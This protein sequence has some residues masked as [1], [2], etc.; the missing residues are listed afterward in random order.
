MQAYTES[1]ILSELLHDSAPSSRSVWTPSD[2]TD[3]DCEGRVTFEF[4]SRLL[5]RVSRDRRDLFQKL[6]ISRRNPRV[7]KIAAKPRN[8]AAIDD[9]LAEDIARVDEGNVDAHRDFPP[10]ESATRSARGDNA[11]PVAVLDTPWRE[12]M[13]HVR[14]GRLVRRSKPARSKMR[15]DERPRHY[16]AASLSQPVS[17]R[18]KFSRRIARDVREL[19]YT[20][21]D[22]R[23]RA[24]ARPDSWTPPRQDRLHYIHH[25]Q[26]CRCAA[27]F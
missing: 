19:R 10:P 1:N 23:A 17:L 25:G 16:L 8:V 18:R 6:R 14:R 9:E 4:P 11:R 22:D 12:I 27:S 24:T 13:L 5:Q 3:K 20:C 26:E 7:A 15:H 21:A 2:S